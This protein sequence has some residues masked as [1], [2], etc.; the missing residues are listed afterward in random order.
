MGVKIEGDGKFSLNPLKKLEEGAVGGKRITGAA[1]GFAVG[2]LGNKG[3]PFKALGGAIRGAVG[4]QGLS[5][6][7]KH[8][9]DV[10]RQLRQA[11]LDGS[12]FGGRMNARWTNLTGSKGI[13]NVEKARKR[14]EA[15]NET[16]GAISKM[17]DRAIEKIKNGEA[18]SLSSNYLG[19][20]AESERIQKQYSET[21]NASYTRNGVT[22]TG[23]DAVAQSQMDMNNFLNETAKYAYMNTMLNGSATYVDE[24]GTTQTISTNDLGGLDATF[25]SLE[26]TWRSKSQGVSGI[27]TPNEAS[28]IH[29]EM[30]R[31]KG[32]ISELDNKTRAQNAS[33]EADKKYVEAAKWKK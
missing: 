10:N 7:A 14:I 12:T 23:R 22:Y 32:E 27:S 11:K 20:K 21:G 5:A 8:Q 15:L 16:S 1:A 26:K 28:E 31:Q 24:T 29:K 9:A 3:N 6:T 17:E 2:A 33:N 30:G 19:I 4:N 13:N 25:K 18:G